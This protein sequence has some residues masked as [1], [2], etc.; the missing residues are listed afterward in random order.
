MASSSSAPQV[1]QPH[2]PVQSQNDPEESYPQPIST[3]KLPAYQIGDKVVVRPPSIETDRIKIANLVSAN[4]DPPSW[5]EGY[6]DIVSFLWYHPLQKM[7]CEQPAWVFQDLLSEFWA[8]CHVGKTNKGSK[9]AITG[10]ILNNSVNVLITTK[11]IKSAF[12]FEYKPDKKYVEA[13]SHLKAKTILSKLGYSEK[14]SSVIKL[15]YLPGIWNYLL[16]TLSKSLQVKSGSFDQPN[17]LELQ[18][19]YSMIKMKEV[20]FAAMIMN[21]LVSRVNNKGLT[22]PY[23]RI[24]A[25]LIEITLKNDYSL[26]TGQTVEVKAIANS[27]YNPRT[28]QQ[29]LLPA[30]RTFLDECRQKEHDEAQSDSA[31]QTDPI[32]HGKESEAE[33]STTQAESAQ[34]KV[35]KKKGKSATSS[36]SPKLPSS[37]LVLKEGEE[38]VT[39]STT[40]AAPSSDPS[41]TQSVHPTGEISASPSVSK[42][43]RTFV[44]KPVTASRVDK[45]KVKF[46]VSTDASHAEERS[47]ADPASQ[48]VQT[49][50]P[51]PSALSKKSADEIK[52]KPTST[53]PSKKGDSIERQ[54]PSQDHTVSTPITLSSPSKQDD[55]ITK[56][57]PMDQ[58]QIQVESES[59]H[60]PILSFEQ[61]L[62]SESAQAV[63]APSIS[64]EGVQASTSVPK[65]SVVPQHTTDEGLPTFPN[66]TSA[67]SVS[68]LVEKQGDVVDYMAFFMNAIS[69]PCAAKGTTSAPH[70]AGEKPITISGSDSSFDDMSAHPSSRDALME[71]DS[72]G[73]DQNKDQ[74]IS[75]VPQLEST[76]E[77]SQADDMAIISPTLPH[78]THSHEE[79]RQDFF[80]SYLPKFF[81]TDNRDC[82]LP[83]EFYES[84]A[85][86]SPQA[87]SSSLTDVVGQLTELKSTFQAESS[88]LQASHE[89]QKTFLNSEVQKMQIS[90]AKLTDSLA[91]LATQVSNLTASHQNSMAQI[92]KAT[93]KFI[94][95]VASEIKDVSKAESTLKE[96]LM[97]VSKSLIARVQAMD[98]DMLR[99]HGDN[100]VANF[101][102]DTISTAVLKIERFL[103]DDDKKGEKEKED[104]VIAEES[105][106][107]KKESEHVRKGVA[108]LKKFIDERN[109]S[110]P[111]SLSKDLVLF[112]PSQVVPLRSVRP[113]IEG[114][115]VEE[116]GEGV[117]ESGGEEERVV[118]EE[119]IVEASDMMKTGGESVS[120]PKSTKGVQ[121][122][123]AQD[124]QADKTKTVESSSSDD[125]VPLGQY[126]LK[127]RKSESEAAQEQ[128]QIKDPQAASDTAQV[129][130]QTKDSDFILSA[131]DR[132]EFI[133]ARAK[134][135]GISVEEVSKWLDEVEFE[136]RLKGVFVLDLINTVDL[137]DQKL[138]EK[139]AQ[140]DE[141]RLRAAAEKKE[142]KKGKTVVVHTKPSLK[143]K[144]V[145]SGVEFS[146]QLD[147]LDRRLLTE[148]V[149]FRKYKEA[150][151]DCQLKRRRNETL[152]SLRVTRVGFETSIETVDLDK[153]GELGYTEWVKLHNIIHF[154]KGI[155]R[156]TVLVALEKR[157][158]K[159][160]L[161]K[162]DISGY[163]KPVG[164]ETED[165]DEEDVENRPLK[166]K[167]RITAPEG[168]H[169]DF[170]T[171]LNPQEF[172]QQ[173]S[174]ES[175]EKTLRFLNLSLPSNVPLA[176]AGLF[177]EE[178]EH[179]I[180]F[181][182]PT[183]RLAFQ[184]T[185][186]LDKAP[187][188]HLFALYKICMSVK[189]RSKGYEKFVIDQGLRRSIDVTKAP[190]LEVKKEAVELIEA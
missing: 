102:L 178:P 151:K 77:S 72:G 118:E 60:T 173:L 152:P 127:K 116:M 8:S 119:M 186:E 166:R 46:V 5:A 139:I 11:R 117:K 28:V 22:I 157:F 122:D 6:D 85:T 171:S 16:S 110:T 113:T 158:E 114:E 71:V 91:N 9:P 68:A 58:S 29:E 126:M 80:A 62:H 156:D 95:T 1:E 92:E 48:V 73:V 109:K 129:Q 70:E 75:T 21:D 30:M 136:A 90:Q 111:L 121:S 20:D 146:S 155:H 185:A 165:D 37:S 120:S 82:G 17:A 57:K 83:Y 69:A 61:F 143:Q 41:K 97:G 189:E 140:T 176:T 188:M 133:E 106:R 184:R 147:K 43:K 123:S 160:K 86:C 32:I 150:I 50:S 183:G 180:Y 36:S 149:K 63:N 78:E 54:I 38:L 24:L 65:D 87:T 96:E 76:L 89:E 81:D 161:L 177:I 94:T 35:G 55:D 34:T 190:S 4:V 101:R 138:K 145:A 14:L 153:L 172:L 141:E 105:A 170:I 128:E 49:D 10:T 124:P 52:G 103:L 130:D 18:I 66:I 163:P 7:L 40:L 144:E 162:V 164:L 137:E 47:K 142:K 104:A 23:G 3:N 182:T 154:Q 131:D 135:K 74:Q 64:Q 53:P 112:A 174:K 19:F 39:S 51:S 179:G 27:I 12:E 59:V 148:K 167:K 168:R 93:E 26:A 108:E 169:E 33:P 13:V 79:I 132:S 84:Y 2:S 100:C 88:K 15:K 159:M 187:H 175:L 31:T 56:G 25:L 98:E 67:T 42:K 115:M 44:G 134:E 45:L 125:N 99:I 107:K 181:I